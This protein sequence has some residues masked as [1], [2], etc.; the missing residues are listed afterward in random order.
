M[1]KIVIINTGAGASLDKFVDG[2]MAMQDAKYHQPGT[3]FT[4]HQM[5]DEEIGEQESLSSAAAHA[6]DIHHG[7]W[8]SSDGGK[9][10]HK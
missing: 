1:P 10:W 5:S 8:V 4:S 6:S 9:T 7:D 3:H 2:I